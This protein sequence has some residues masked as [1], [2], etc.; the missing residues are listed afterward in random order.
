[1]ATHTLIMRD[2]FDAPTA[3]HINDILFVM[4]V[5]DKKHL[6]QVYDKNG[7]AFISDVNIFHDAVNTNQHSLKSLKND[8]WID[9]DYW[10]SDQQKPNTFV[11]VSF[12]GR[13]TEVSPHDILLIVQKGSVYTVYSESNIFFRPTTIPLNVLCPSHAFNFRANIA[14]RKGM[15]P[16]DVQRRTY[17][18][19]LNG[20]I[21]R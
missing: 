13:I 20:Y 15:Q 5:L 7:Q 6:L 8:V 17:A 3:V 18:V 10:S 16:E 14:C 21:K 19:A 9:Q 1:M 4:P 2:M 11:M 12:L